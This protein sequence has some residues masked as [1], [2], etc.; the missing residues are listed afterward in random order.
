MSGLLPIS[1]TLQPLRG[2]PKDYTLSFPHPPSRASA[3]SLGGRPPDAIFPT[4]LVTLDAS[5][6]PQQARPEVHPAT[7]PTWRSSV[8]TTPGRGPG[9]QSPPPPNF[10]T[11]QPRCVVAWPWV[12]PCCWK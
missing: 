9:L 1:F 4:T 12:G 8:T 6:A 7:S 5:S 11:A 2:A 3:L 10:S